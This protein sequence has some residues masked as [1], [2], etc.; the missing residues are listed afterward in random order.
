MTNENLDKI[1]REKMERFMEDAV[2]A[3]A[4]FAI[5]EGLTDRGEIVRRCL[6]IHADLLSDC[7]DLILGT[8]RGSEERREFLK[9]ALRDAYEI[10]RSETAER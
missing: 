7:R 8:F 2:T 1:A 4:P 6:E 9:A 3:Y 10:H 5:A